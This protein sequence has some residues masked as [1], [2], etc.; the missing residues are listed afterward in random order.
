[1]PCCPAAACAEQRPAP[2]APRWGFIAR[3]RPRRM[4]L[5]DLT[6]DRI[7]RVC[8]AQSYERGASYYNSGRITSVR[9]AGGAVR[10]IVEG[11]DVYNVELA[12][13]GG[14]GKYY[15]DCP[16]SYEGECKHVVAVLLHVRDHS[17][18]MIREAKSALLAAKRLLDGA[19]EGRLREFLA[20]EMAGDPALAERFARG[21]GAPLPAAAGPADPSEEDEEE[22]EADEAGGGKGPS[23]GAAVD[24]FD[25]VSSMYRAE[26]AAWRRAGATGCDDYGHI[27]LKGP[28]GEAAALAR[29][30][31]M[32]GASRAYGQ[33]ASAVSDYIDEV[34]GSH[35]P[36]LRAARTAIARWATCMDKSGPTD[37]ERREC[38]SDALSGYRGDARFSAA[39][40][41]A[42]WSLCRS[43]GDLVHLLDLV[44]PHMPD[45]IPADGSEGAG[46]RRVKRV[47]GPL[48]RRRRD[49]IEQESPERIRMLRIQVGAL[50]GLGRKRDIDRLLKE[51]G[52]ADPA[53]CAMR[54]G[55]L[56][57]S[58]DK[59]GAVRAADKG[60]DLFGNDERI[61]AAAEAVYGGREAGRVPVL[62]GLFM[63]TL[64]WSYY[65]KLR[66]LPGWRRERAAVLEWLSSD[67]D[68][69]E[70]L[71]RMLVS[72]GMHGRA[73]REIAESDDAALFAEYAETVAAGRP[74][75]YLAAYGR[76]V[77]GLADS[78]RS[79]W[80]YSR[81]AQ[82]L[83]HMSGIEGGREAAARIAA[84]IV[85]RNP[86][87]RAH[88]KALAPYVKRASARTSAAAAR[89]GGGSRAG[90]PRAARGRA[91]PASS[92]KR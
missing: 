59:A 87:K 88:L 47:T 85:A 42:L 4:G 41:S 24:Y 58:G 34:I 1:M 65:D 90:G 28:M 11:T 8:T 7:R 82:Y 15:C 64:D 9:L 35:G 70:M 73:L 16:Y 74:R 36:H 20:V 46:S 39:Y 72:E 77:A 63:R 84:D 44:A 86:S 67:E 19:G 14:D 61:M 57:G 54:V 50:E 17:A 23:E 91:R 53:A 10:A 60:L 66:G 78:A 68:R 37:D 22:E 81:V 26:T 27:D 2:G 55:R 76:C 3:I 31:D 92:R 29:S 48:R 21:A 30:G 25:R 33:I 5:P 49:L 18:E 32:A 79:S 56:A 52:R 43:D 38:V 69:Y 40:E 71:V 75:A 51:H 80:D 45:P 13:N 62:S 89:S 83:K 6:V 12:W